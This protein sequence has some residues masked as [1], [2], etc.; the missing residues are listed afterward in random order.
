ML[1]TTVGYIHQLLFI[2]RAWFSKQPRGIASIVNT[3]LQMKKPRFGT[4]KWL[5]QGYTASEGKEQHLGKDVARDM[6]RQAGPLVYIEIRGVWL[7]TF[8]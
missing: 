7:L 8:F 6:G 3:I 1:I 2:C 5:A 4:I